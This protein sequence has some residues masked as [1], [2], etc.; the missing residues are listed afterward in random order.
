MKARGWDD[1]AWDDAAARLRERGW[2]AGEELTAEGR[3]M[4]D[5]IE[6]DTDRLAA[7]PWRTLGDDGCARLAELLVP[8]RFAVVDAGDW[9]AANPI[10]VPDP[11]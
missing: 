1:A 8:L 5:L 3:A 6:A 9:P 2:L 10:G 11:E 7:G 4:V